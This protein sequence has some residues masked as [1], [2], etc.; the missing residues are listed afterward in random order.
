[1]T[2]IDPGLQ[3]RHRYVFR[4]LATLL[5]VISALSVAAP[6]ARAADKPL[7]AKLVDIDGKRVKLSELR[8]K[9]VLL[10][11][12]AT[13]CLP[14]REQ[15]QILHDLADFFAERGIAV[16]SVDEGEDPEKVEKHL[17]SSPSAFPVLLDRSQAIANKM[18]IGELPALVLLRADGTIA[19]LALGVTR[20][21]GIEEMLGQLR[22]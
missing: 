9:P 22:E 8:G 7:E 14:C 20:Q 19:G 13:W 12:W 4:G 11:L 15:T 5:L 21:E 18:E 17:E 16:Y 10:D 2:R 3:S 1:M 6:V